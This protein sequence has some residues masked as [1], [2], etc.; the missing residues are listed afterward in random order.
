MVDLKHKI[1]LKIGGNFYDQDAFCKP[2]KP[3]QM[4]FSDLA[5]FILIFN[6]FNST[7]N[8]RKFTFYSGDIRMEVT[9]PKRS[10]H[11]IYIYTVL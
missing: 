10:I 7:S 2:S 1:H 9:I 4:Y 5:N 8:L 3:I 6:I 11:V